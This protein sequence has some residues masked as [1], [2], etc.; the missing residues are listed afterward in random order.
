MAE[1]IDLNAL[2][3]E[4]RI[5]KIGDKEVEIKPPKTAQMFKL[6]ALGQKMQGADKIAPEE[7]EGLVSEM[8]SLIVEIAPELDGVELHSAQVFK[9]IEIVG[10]MVNGGQTESPKV[11]QR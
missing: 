5:V 11:E 7:I 9:L 6:G 8:T 3:P 1:V 10:E 4:S 2:V